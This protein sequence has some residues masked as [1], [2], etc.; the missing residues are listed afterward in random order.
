MRQNE[1]KSIKVSRVLK[2]EHRAWSLSWSPVGD[3]IWAQ[4]EKRL[5]SW[6]ILCLHRG[7]SS[8]RLT[9]QEEH[10]RPIVYGGR[11]RSCGHERND[12]DSWRS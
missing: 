1:P 10:Q 3:D 5:D 11:T 2:R 12:G 6:A 9:P 8:R 7:R 4:S